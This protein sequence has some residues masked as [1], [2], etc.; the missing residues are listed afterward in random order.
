LGEREA[1]RKLLEE[2]NAI[3]LP[4]GARPVLARAQALAPRR[5]RTPPSGY[6]G[7]L[8]AREGEVLVLITEGRSNQEIADEL[9]LSVRTVERHINKLYAKI[10]ARGRA[11]AVAYAARHGLL[12]G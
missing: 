7:G 11:D 12:P 6:P 4:L 3:C 8:T 1:V 2:V 9:W 10:D 5:P